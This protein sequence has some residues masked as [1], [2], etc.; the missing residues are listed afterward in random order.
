MGRLCSTFLCVQNVY[1]PRLYQHTHWH[2]SG[3]KVLGSWQSLS[4]R[5]GM[6]DSF[7]WCAFSNFP[8]QTH[9]LDPEKGS[10]QRRAH[11]HPEVTRWRWRA[12]KV[13]SGGLG[14][15]SWREGWH[16]GDRAQTSLE[17]A[18][19]CMQ[20]TEVGAGAPRGG[21]GTRRQHKKARLVSLK[22]TV[23]PWNRLPF[24]A[25]SSLSHEVCKQMG[26]W[27]EG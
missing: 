8:S 2:P 26:S 17:P 6:G 9:V 24:K 14:P 10:H 22:G 7:S 27:Q 21:R 16:S 12:G 19:A 18:G 20:H 11:S 5:R 3:G 4:S 13:T 23:L 25:V 15:V 1:F